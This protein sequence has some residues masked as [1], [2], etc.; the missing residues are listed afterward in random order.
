MSLERGL[1]GRALPIEV[2]A[3][4][5]VLPR[6]GDGHGAALR[7]DLRESVHRLHPARRGRVGHQHHRQHAREPDGAAVE[8]GDAL[9]G[10]GGRGRCSSTTCTTA[11]RTSSSG[12]PIGEVLQPGRGRPRPRR[13]PRVE[14]RHALRRAPRE[15]REALGQRRAAALLLH[16]W[17]ARATTSNDDQIPFGAGPDRP[18][19]PRARVRPDPE[20]AAAPARALGLV[21]CC[22]SSCGSPAIWTI[23]SGVPMDI[24]MPDASHRVPTL[25]RNA[26]G[27]E[28]KTAAELNAYI[29][30]L[31]AERRD[32]RRAAAA[33]ERRRALQ[34][35]LRLARPAPVAPLPAHRRRSASRRSSSASTCSTSRTSWASPSPTTRASR[36]CWR[37]TAPTPATPASCARRPSAAR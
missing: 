37:A 12:G 24:L 35:Q 26:G 11:A 31:N 20:R 34:R 19:R 36:T 15:P 22:R 13:E 5:V 21:R 18:E 33:R 10:A 28:F 4:N 29:T 3:G 9:Q 7:A 17:R 16:A 8:P 6:P 14:R 32:R 1:D 23:A 30:S 27:R 25:S 2:R